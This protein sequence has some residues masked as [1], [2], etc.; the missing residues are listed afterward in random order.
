MRITYSFLIIFLAIFITA[1]NNSAVPTT[2]TKPAPTKIEPA[3][4]KNNPGTIPTAVTHNTPTVQS[5]SELDPTKPLLTSTLS[6]TV[7]PE[8]TDTSLVQI[9][10]DSAPKPKRKLTPN[11]WKRLPII[12]PVSDSVALI[13]QRGLELGVDYAVTRSCY[14]PTPVGE[15]C[16]QCDSCQLRLKGFAEVGVH[17]PAPYRPEAFATA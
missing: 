13:Y 8:G 11:A 15:A 16:G 4:D 17:D 3:A 6:A 2:A 12:P 10:Q 5:P 14:D 9:P 7:Q 1:C